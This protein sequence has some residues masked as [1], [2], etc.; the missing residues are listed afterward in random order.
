MVTGSLDS[1]I[2]IWDLNNNI[3]LRVLKQ[4]T[5]RVLCVKQHSSGQLLSGSEDHSVCVWDPKNGDLV[6]QHKNYNNKTLICN[7][8]ELPNNE[9]L[10]VCADTSKELGL[11]IWR[12]ENGETLINIAPV[13]EAPIGFSASCMLSGGRI[14]LGELNANGGNILIFDVESAQFIQTH[15]VHEGSIYQIVK[16]NEGHIITCSSDKT[17]KLINLH[18]G[19]VIAKY[20]KHQHWVCSVLLLFKE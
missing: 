7:F 17:L 15:S 16:G 13:K 10:S 9:I 4:H 1:T 2:R 11:R 8:E 3:L 18:T 19:K 12:L 14:V 5:D 20:L 6:S